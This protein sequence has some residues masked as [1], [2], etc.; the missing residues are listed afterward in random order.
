MIQRR[1]PAKTRRRPKKRR[2]KSKPAT[3]DVALTI[4]LLDK[5]HAPTPQAAALFE[6]LKGWLKD[7]SG[8]DEEAWPALKKALNEERDRVGARRLFDG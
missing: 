2:A 4:A 7:E 1:S 3:K 6:L 5:M 8:Y